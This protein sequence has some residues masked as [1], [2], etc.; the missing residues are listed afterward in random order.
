MCLS[1]NQDVG[2]RNRWTQTCMQIFTD[3]LIKNHAESRLRHT[4][5][6]KP[7]ERLR[8]WAA[9]VSRYVVPILLHITEKKLLTVAVYPA[10]PSTVA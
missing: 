9:F 5:L 3:E 6:L 1:V 7:A 8:P 2:N 10:V 4:K